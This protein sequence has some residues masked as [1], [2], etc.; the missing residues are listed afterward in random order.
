MKVK[1]FDTK[2]LDEI[3]EK[4]METVGDSKSEIFEIGERCREDFQQLTEE[5]K[6]LKQSVIETIEEGDKLDREARFARN[7]LSISKQAL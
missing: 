7:R 1:Q 6:E 2:V 3:L 5:L 4:M